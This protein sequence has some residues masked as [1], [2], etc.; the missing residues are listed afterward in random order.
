MYEL[1]TEDTEL[2]PCGQWIIPKR[3]RTLEE[4]KEE[5]RA[6]RTK[7]LAETDWM[8]LPDSPMR[9]VNYD[10]AIEYRQMLRDLPESWYFPHC[11]VP[12]F[13]HIETLV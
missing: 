4:L 3:E 8:L 10:R 11:S 6:L 5:V 13:H 2:S 7:K 9:G 1:M 12:E